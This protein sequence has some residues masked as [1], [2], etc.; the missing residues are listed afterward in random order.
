MGLQRDQGS[1][2]LRRRAPSAAIGRRPRT[3]RPRSA[4]SAPPTCRP[5]PGWRRSPMP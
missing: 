3:A 5:R 2:R 4:I 1:R